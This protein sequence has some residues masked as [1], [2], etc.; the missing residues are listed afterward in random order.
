MIMLQPLTKTM[1]E[2]CFVPLDLSA[3]FDTIDHGNLFSI[4]ERYVGIGGSLL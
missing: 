2:K 4:L 1:D 3:T